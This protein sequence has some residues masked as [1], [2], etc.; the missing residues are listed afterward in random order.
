MQIVSGRY[1][2]ERMSTNQSVYNNQ[3]QDNK[4]TGGMLQN[5]E[6]VGMEFNTGNKSKM[7]TKSKPIDIKAAK[8]CL[9]SAIDPLCWVS[10][11]SLACH[12]CFRIVSDF[13]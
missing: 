3:V 10:A 7:R 9:S 13:L 6:V 5:I 12:Q 8:R 4:T 11:P 1:I 2:T